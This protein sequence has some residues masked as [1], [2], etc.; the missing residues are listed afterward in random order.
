[1]LHNLLAS[2]IWVYNAQ[3]NLNELCQD[4]MGAGSCLR[5][6][7][8]VLEAPWTGR[9]G[10]LRQGMSHLPRAGQPDT[11]HLDEGWGWDKAGLGHEPT[12]GVHVSHEQRTA[13]GIAVQ[14]LEQRAG[15][16][17]AGGGPA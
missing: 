15:G 17:Q 4:M 14:H 10:A 6:L 16:E 8:E 7:L 3:I 11:G 13:L 2:Q 1:M 12:S 5:V 9:E